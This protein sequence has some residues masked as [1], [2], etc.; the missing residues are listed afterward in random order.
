MEPLLTDAELSELENIPL[1]ERAAAVEMIERR[2]RSSMEDGTHVN[3]EEP[4]E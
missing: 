1:E 3:A 4:K 2:L